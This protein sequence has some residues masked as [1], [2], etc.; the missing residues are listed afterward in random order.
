MNTLQPLYSLVNLLDSLQIKQYLKSL[1]E[2]QNPVILEIGSADG[3]DTQEF[4]EL[5]GSGLTVHC[6]EP[7]PRNLDV[8]INGG[9]RE[10][11]PYFSG[12]VSGATVFLN[13]K[14]VGEI[15]GKT[16]FY[17]TST[18]YSSS[19]KKPNKNLSINWPSIYL[20]NT[21][22]IESISLDS[23]VKEKN[24]QIIDLIWADVQGGEDLM[25]KGG[26]D[27]FKNKVRYL[28]TE[29]A[30]DENN[31]Y[32]EETPFLKDILELLGDDWIIHTDFG[33]DVLLKNTK[34]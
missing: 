18:I 17:Q 1:I 14:A 8:F 5:F 3:I 16:N 15:D 4:I 33:P 34:L 30:K 29:Y 26:V 10:C 21:L 25:I 23:Y 24:I 28:Y 9:L 6:F 27:S 19:L 20:Q 32:Y 13:A 11:K 7:D 12:P 31:R 22:E 2:E